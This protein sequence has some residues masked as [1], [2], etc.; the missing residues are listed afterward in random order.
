M[1]QDVATGRFSA[2]D[3]Y[4]STIHTEQKQPQFTVEF[5]KSFR[6]NFA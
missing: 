5:R 1:C 3:E 2:L 6:H 4:I